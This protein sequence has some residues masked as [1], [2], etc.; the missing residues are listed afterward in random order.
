MSEVLRAELQVGLEG[1]TQPLQLATQQVANFAQSVTTQ[2]Q[3]A[4]QSVTTLTQAQQA[5]SQ[6]AGQAAQAYA[7][8]SS[9]LNQVVQAI[10]SNTQA[11]VTSAQAQQ[12]TT[13]AV[14]Q[15]TQAVQALGQAQQQSANTTSTWTRILQVAAGVGLT[16]SVQ[17]MV[18]ALRQLATEAVTN[19]TKMQALEASFKAITGSTAAAQKELA[20]VR[21]TANRTGTDFL[22]AAQ[23]FKGLEAAARGTSLEGEKTHAIFTA[24]TEASRVM[25]LGA[26]ETQRALLALEQMLSK[27]KVSAEELRRQLGNALPGAFQIAARAMGQT[28]EQFDQMLRQYNCC[29]IS[30]PVSAYVNGIKMPPDN[31]RNIPLKSRNEI[32]IVYGTPPDVIPTAYQWPSSMFQ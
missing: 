22:V 27:G 15:T 13:Q 30:T 12:A 5:T 25:G 31:T 7:T 17:G 23:S 2:L 21:E 11:T 4:T 24:I 3:R 1:F 8:L 9:Q 19:A 10:R 29:N 20:F 14:Q 26:N 28:T 32:A 18:G 16:V 6:M